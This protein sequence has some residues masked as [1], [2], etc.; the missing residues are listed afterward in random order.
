MFN[1][2][3]IAMPE[4][5]RQGKGDEQLL[6]MFRLDIL[7]DEDQSV[8]QGRPIFRDVDWIRIYIPGDK[9]TVID[10]PAYDSDR[11]RSPQHYAR[12]KQGLKDEEQ[13]VGTPLKEWPLV[14]RSQ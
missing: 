7:K 12:Y 3:A 2:S 10:R 8:A 6:V 9:S 13:Q 14:T 5:F 11:L 1:D 4:D